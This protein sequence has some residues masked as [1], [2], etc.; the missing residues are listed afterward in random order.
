MAGLTLKQQDVIVQI[1]PLLKTYP[2]IL[3][4]TEQKK[5]T[6]PVLEVCERQATDKGTTRLKEY[7]RI[8]NGSLATCKPAIQYIMS[9]VTDPEG[10][11]LNLQALL[12]GRIS[13]TRRYAI[14]SA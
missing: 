12:D 10:R 7:G 4:V 11:P 2:W 14:S 13:C 6:G 5:F 8:Y 1:Q 3:R 9:Q